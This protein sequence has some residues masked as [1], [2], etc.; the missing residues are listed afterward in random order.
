MLTPNRES[1]SGEPGPKSN[2]AYQLCDF[3]YDLPKQL[4]AQYPLEQRSSSRLL[5]LTG[6]VLKDHLFAD[7]PYLLQPG[8]LLVLN[9]SKVMPARMV[10]RKE[11][12]GAVEVLIE[13]V[14]SSGQ[15]A[16]R[17][18]W[19]QVASNKPL[20][21]SSRLWLEGAF[22]A[23]V[24]N[25]R[26]RFYQLFFETNVH[27]LMQKHGRLPLPP[28]ITRRVEREDLQR[29]QTV[30]ARDVGSVAAPTAGL[31]FD[32]ELLEKMLSKGIKTCFVTLHVGAGTFVPVSNRNINQ[33][34]MHSEAWQLPEATVEAI[35][36]TK[37]AGGRVVAVGTT[38]LR[39]LESAALACHA[40][41]AAELQPGSGE[42]DLFILPGF[43]FR[44]ADVLLT[45]FHLPKSTLL[46]LVA[47]FAGLEKIQAAYQHAI[48]H[49]YRFFSYG[50]VTLISRNNHEI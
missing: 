38:S 7:L 34:H 3:D 2:F 24:R 49:K 41:T 35:K 6:N 29:Y 15:D 13:R 45:N 42:T 20:R 18:A 17:L 19:V 22:W 23:T 16:H 25:R 26:E 47:A 46:M 1:T 8:D 37:A 44:I 32:A 12:G 27:E 21:I 10:G 50:D 11:S 14:I 9:N 36:A 5:V 28:Y 48:K 39:V 30:Y 31:H 33:H 40:P 43:D 4:I